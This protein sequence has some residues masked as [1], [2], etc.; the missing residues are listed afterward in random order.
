[1]GNRAS[2]AWGGLEDEEG[3]AKLKEGDGEDEIFA[4]EYE[5]RLFLGRNAI[6]GGGLDGLICK[7]KS[8]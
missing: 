4:S 8:V 6:P 5:R 7:D 1:M 3:E 2:T